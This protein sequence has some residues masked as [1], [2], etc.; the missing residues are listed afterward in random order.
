METAF[1]RIEKFLQKA[2][3]TEFRSRLDFTTPAFGLADLINSRLKK[4]SKIQLMLISNRKL[5]VSSTPDQRH[6]SI[7]EMPVCNVLA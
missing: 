1:K 4:V 7:P 6:N 2:V 5:S 3:D